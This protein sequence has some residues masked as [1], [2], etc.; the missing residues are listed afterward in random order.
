[1]VTNV[2]AT[3]GTK[4]MANTAIK[5]TLTN[6]P[7]VPTAVTNTRRARILTAVTLV[8]A[9]VVTMVM[10]IVA[11]KTIQMNVLLDNT[12]VPLML[13]AKTLDGVSNASASR[14][15][16]V[17]VSIARLI[18]MLHQLQLTHVPLQTVLHTPP[19]SLDHMV[20]PLVNVN[21]VTLDLALVTTVVMMLMNA[22]TVLMVVQAMQDV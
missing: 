9:T 3:T 22:T 21:Q 1:M 20:V 12:T 11:S 14:D 10:V 18:T 8:I 19:V 15:I 7:M 6:V 17:M 13:N 2:F 5:K 4:A 16:A